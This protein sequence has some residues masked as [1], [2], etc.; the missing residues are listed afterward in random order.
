TNA[1]TLCTG[2]VDPDGPVPYWF[3]FTSALDVTADGQTVWV[4]DPGNHRVLRVHP[5]QT[6]ADLVIGQSD[7]TSAVNGCGSLA[8]PHLCDPTGI[9]YDQAHD[10]LYVMDGRVEG[11]DTGG[12]R[13]F[14]YRNPH[15]NGQAPTEVWNAPADREFTWP[16]GL[17][18]EPGTGAL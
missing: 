7:F 13:I 10:V 1:H 8:D 14:V 11:P 4:A 18:L 6:D 17:T 3:F 16:R 15:A 12:G 5:G 2:V 9:A